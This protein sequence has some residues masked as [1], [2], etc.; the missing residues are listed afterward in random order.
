MQLLLRIAVAPVI[1]GISSLVSRRW[2]TAVGGTLAAM[3]IVS[4]S[5]AFFVSF[6]LGPGFGSRTAAGTLVGVGSLG[7]YALA[8]ARASRRFDWP[9][10]LALSLAVVLLVSVAVVVFAS[11]PGF[12]ALAYALAS[13][14]IASRL[15]P[16]A[17]PSPP[18]T[19]PRWDIPA[20][21]ATATFLVV[22]ITGVAESLGPQLSGLLAAFPLLFS[23]LLVFTH[24]HEGAERARGLLRGFLAGLV[25]TS[26][27]LE[28]IAD[29]IVP[30]GIAP[31]FVLALLVWL[32][33]QVTAIAW[34]HVRHSRW[35]AVP[36]D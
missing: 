32:V 29:C 16:A 36:S 4:G 14:S 15:L 25:A 2:G 30:L 12:V 18:Q 10:S 33:C 23:T 6:E 34:M 1:L 27:F 21:M 28:V 13:L 3:P 20:R 5:V 31:A 35:M 26:M 7:W 9:I 22:A 17:E 8:Y 19:P 24:R 11:V